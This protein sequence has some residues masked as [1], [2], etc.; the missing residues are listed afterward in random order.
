[1]SS[2]SYAETLGPAAAAD[3]TAISRDVNERAL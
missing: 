3:E 1:M 2:L